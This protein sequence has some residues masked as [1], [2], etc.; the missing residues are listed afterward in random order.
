MEPR[1]TADPSPDGDL[2]KIGD[3]AAEA[4]IRRIHVL[5]WRDLDDVEAGGSE[6][7]IHEVARRWAAAGLEVVQRSSF[8]AGQPVRVTRD[9]YESIRQA[10][11]YL[12]FPRAVLSELTGRH[13][14]RDALVEIWNGMPFLSPLWA[15][16]P[17]LVLIH[18]VH[19]DMWR[20][21]LPP[22]L[23]VVGDAIERRLAPRFYRRARI[24]TLSESARQDIHDEMG[25]PLDRISVVP[26]GLH[27]RFLEA[28]PAPAPD[29]TVLVV[30]R[31]VP[32]KRIGLMITAA[33]KARERIP[34]LRL[35]VVGEGYERGDLES[36]IASLGAEAWV[37]LR[38][39]LDADELV[40]AY[41]AAW[42]VGSASLREG[43]GMALTEA[44]AI[45]VPAVATRVLGH[46]DAV[47]EGRTGL[48][49]DE[50]GLAD[51][52]VQVLE[53]SALR[54]RLGVAARRNA[55][56]LSWASTATELMRLLVDEAQ[57]RR[58]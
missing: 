45:G 18:H 31:L 40:E 4:G 46:V 23:A 54:A 49:V 25:L 5:A 8:V 43:W 3:L 55:Q 30:G 42:V 26:P 34:T 57:A 51:A 24:A 56:Q 21:A 53:D 20:M 19:R 27:Q 48:L 47:I 38:G 9:G 52:L 14:R 13:G 17:R 39:R 10:G 15:R 29:P 37:D 36:Q 12:V 16:G 41:R 58:R 6:V 2:G 28:T 44:A 50:H 11:R 35:V 7:H 32:V 22:S 33:A 1:L